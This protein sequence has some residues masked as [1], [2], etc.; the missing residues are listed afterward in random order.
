MRKSTRESGRS[1]TIKSRSSERILTVNIKFPNHYPIIKNTI[2]IEESHDFATLL[3]MI[4][5]LFEELEFTIPKEVGLCVSRSIKAKY[6]KKLKE[7][8][9]FENEERLSNYIKLLENYE[10]QMMETKGITVK[11]K[12]KLPN[13]KSYI[14]SYELPCNS[15]F[16]SLEKIIESNL[17]KINTSRH[18]ERDS[19]LEKKNTIEQQKVFY[20][21]KDAI[22]E[23]E[24]QNKILVNLITNQCFP[25]LKNESLIDSLLI[26]NINHFEYTLIENAKDY[27]H[28]LQGYD[29]IKKHTKK[30]SAPVILEIPQESTS[31]KSSEDSSISISPS[32]SPKSE[33]LMRKSLNEKKPVTKNI[34][35]VSK[36]KKMINSKNSIFSRGSKGKNKMTLDVIP[37]QKKKKNLNLKFSIFFFF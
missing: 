19:K 31:S 26:D 7:F 18:Q 12:K 24:I 27:T 21:P 35:G 33:K 36:I 28:E 22:K 34:F 1:N 9:F 5:K 25:I 3:Q 15:S 17:A 16:H 2:R 8:P 32:K 30:F 14:T 11:V 20:V 29:N 23:E 10:I 4:K 6:A 37:R 13:M